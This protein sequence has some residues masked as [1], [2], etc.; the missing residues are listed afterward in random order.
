MKRRNLDVTNG[1]SFPEE[2]E[3]SVVNICMPPIRKIGKMVIAKMTIPIPPIHWSMARQIK[4]PFGKESICANMVAPVV[5][6]PDILVDEGDSIVFGDTTLNFI[7]TPG[8]TRG[9]MCV[10]CYNN[11]LSK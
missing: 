9:S 5:V 1:E 11:L 6:N 4:K 7:H 3:L 8:H 10:V 2:S